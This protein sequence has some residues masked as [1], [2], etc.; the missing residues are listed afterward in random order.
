MG[1]THYWHRDIE[2]PDEKFKAALKDCRI[3]L[4]GLDIE[5]GDAEGKN[6][7]VLTDD[8]IIFNSVTIGC[9][10]FIFRRIQHPRP[11]RD[12][13]FGYCKTE[14]MPYDLAV[15]CCLIILKHH[16]DDSIQVSSDGKI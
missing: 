14:H 4:S 7:P 1:W 8:E 2:I 10:P 3:I 15:Q 9:E 5:L 6:S 16:F 11:G 12:R 13:V